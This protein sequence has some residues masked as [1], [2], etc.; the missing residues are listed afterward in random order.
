MN[1]GVLCQA[2]QNTPQQY[3]TEDY[4][5]MTEAHVIQEIGNNPGQTLNQLAEKTFR[6]NSGMSL[7]I[8]SLSEKDIG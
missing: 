3:G 7:V 8:K 5:Y 1:L 4:L 6:T 2:Y